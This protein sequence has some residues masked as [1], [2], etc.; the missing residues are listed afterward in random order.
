MTLQPL[1]GSTTIS[2]RCPP[3]PPRSPSSASVGGADVI[4]KEAWV[5]EEPK[6]PKGGSPTCIPCLNLK[7]DN[8]DLF[9]HCPGTWRA[10]ALGASQP[11]CARACHKCIPCYSMQDCSILGI[12]YPKL[13]PLVEIGAIS[14]YTRGRCTA[15]AFAL[16]QPVVSLAS[17]SFVIR[18]EAEL[19]CR[20]SSSVRLWW[21]FEEPK[22]PKG[23]SRSP[24]HC[25]LT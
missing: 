9:L 10:Q 6:G 14:Y 4:R 7:V 8:K 5:L 1:L 24:P 11:W 25:C 15:G 23:H 21:E 12:P 17:L 18:K 20:T 3:L 22:G 13:E 16:R 2:G 19:S